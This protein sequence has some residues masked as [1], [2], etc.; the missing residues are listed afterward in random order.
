MEAGGKVQVNRKHDVHA[1]AS[2]RRGRRAGRGVVGALD[3]GFRRV[4]GAGREQR[5]GQPERQARGGRES[6]TAEAATAEVAKG[7]AAGAG[8]SAVGC[9]WRVVRHLSERGRCGER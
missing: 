6:A 8:G 9:Q 4:G 2:A 5:H 1:Q 3:R 7:G